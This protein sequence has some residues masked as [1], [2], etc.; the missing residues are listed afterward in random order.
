MIFDLI[1]AVN[2]C[3]ARPQLRVLPQV[4]LLRLVGAADYFLNCIRRESNGKLIRKQSWWFRVCSFGCPVIVLRRV[5][6][7]SLQ[8]TIWA[9]L[10]QSMK[11]TF[12][13]THAKTK[14]PRLV[15]GAKHEIRKYLKRER[16]KTLPDIAGFWDFDCRFGAS[17]DDCVEIDVGEIGKCID[18]IEAKQGESFYIEI[19]AKPGQRVKK[20]I[21][22]TDGSGIGLDDVA[23]EGKAGGQRS[24]Q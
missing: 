24:S 11:K 3:L 10:F 21:A 18:A 5:G 2:H 12:Q 14:Y 4:R 7:H 1:A 8:F 9:L 15:E 16:G 6:K 13:L 23:A 17:S 19:L 20:Q 22:R